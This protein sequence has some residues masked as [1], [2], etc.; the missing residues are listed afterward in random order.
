MQVQNQF[1]VLCKV[2]F[3][4]AVLSSLV[5]QYDFICVALQFNSLE[6]QPWFCGTLRASINHQA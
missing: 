3:S 5:H 2:K 6:L 4:V 1:Q